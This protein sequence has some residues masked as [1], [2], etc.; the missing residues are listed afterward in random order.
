[1]SIPLYQSQQI[2]ELES[3]VIRDKINTVPGLMELAGQAALAVL[4]DSWPHAKQ[5]IICC[6][7][8]NNG[9][10]GYVLA[11]LAHERGLKPTIFA[12]SELTD[13]KDAALHAAQ[14]CQQ[15]GIPIQKF[16]SGTPFIGDVI[17]DALLG[18]GLHGSVQEPYANFIREI[19][20]TGLPIF[21]I[22]VPSGIDANTGRICGLA[23]KADVTVTMLA[24]KAGLFTGHGP[25]FCGKIVSNNLDVPPV[26]FKKIQPAAELLEW[27]R[28]KSLLPKR[29]SDTHKGDYGHVLV[30][31]GD[32]G[33]GGAVR[34]AA[35]AALRI[36]AGLVSVATRPEHV[37]VVNCSRPEIMCHQ[38]AQA[39][40]IDPLLQ[41]ATV[42][43]LGPGLGQ[44][45]WSKL[46]FK[47][48]MESPLP[49]VVDAD[50]LNLLSGH[51]HQ[52]DQWVLTPHPGEAARLIKSTAHHIQDD[53][54]V[55]AKQ[56]QEKYQGVVVLKG[57]GTIIKSAKE[58]PKV[59]PAGNPG[60]ASGGMG[61]VLSGVIGGLIAQKL[62]LNRAAE[63][64]VLVHSTAADRAATEGGERGL[65]ATDLMSHL[66]WLVNS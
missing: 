22:D 11:R 24:L 35:E 45:D 61:D 51:P 53:R 55:A 17:V 16:E 36:G 26:L 33:M 48:V 20:Q 5:I 47:K 15:I 58:L 12:V 1:M 37:P 14:R 28:L 21:S 38:V 50:G 40:D 34:M 57:V 54:F 6:G 9:G 41:K 56:I 27:Y 64:G 19:N 44:S 4:Q 65:L 62:P 18:I 59:C 31:G 25:A 39:D 52:S 10:D 66:R 46:L 49:K 8:G 7:K 32:Y 23:V 29:A 2:Q 43:V 13:L 60:M 30:V 3:L 42:V 63:I